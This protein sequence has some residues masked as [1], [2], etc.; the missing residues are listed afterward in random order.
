[1]DRR[2]FLKSTGGAGLLALLVPATFVAKI[3]QNVSEGGLLAWMKSHHNE[4]KYKI[5]TVGDF[6]ELSE[7]LRQ[8]PMTYRECYLPAGAELNEE[9]YKAYGNMS[10]WD[11]MRVMK[12]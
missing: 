7:R 1:M 6:G 11:V 3:F 9:L 5:T 4:V 10:S 12:G 8:Y 2:E